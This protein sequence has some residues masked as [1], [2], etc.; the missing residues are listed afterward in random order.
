MRSLQESVLTILT[1]WIRWNGICYIFPVRIPDA[2]LA[3]R[4]LGA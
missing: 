3:S 4:L 1:K 2:G